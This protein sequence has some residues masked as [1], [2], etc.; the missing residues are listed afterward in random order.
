MEKLS[1]SMELEYY[2]D[3]AEELEYYQEAKTEQIFIN[4]SVEMV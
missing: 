2:E 3:Q 1:S 4:G